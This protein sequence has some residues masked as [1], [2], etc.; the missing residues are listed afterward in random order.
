MELIF[1]KNVKG[2]RGFRFPGS[3][4]PLQAKIDANFARKQDAPL[5]EVAELDVTRH[6]TLLSQKN[7]SIDTHFYPLGSCTMKYNPKFTE[8]LARLAGFT[9]LHPLLPQLAGGEKLTQGA[10]QILHELEALM[11]A[12][13][14]FTQFTLQPLAGA[15]GELTGIMLMAAYHKARGNSKKKYV[16]IPD[17]AHGTNPASA[18]VAGYQTIAIPS[19]KDGG[20]DLAALKA[21]INDEVAGLMMTVPSTYGVFEPNISE[22]AELI[23][24]V[25]GIMYYD[26][27]NLNAV[28]GKCRPGDL[29]FDVMHINTHKTF[30][31]PHGGGGP[32][33]G[34]VGV[35]DKLARY[36][37]VSRVVKNSDGTYALSYDYPDSIGY[38]A[39]FYGNFGLLVRAY[40]YI[41]ML[42]REG[43]I[44][45]ANHAVLNANY[46]MA[47][48]KPYYKLCFDRLC[49]HESVFSASN[50]AAR[51]VH[52]TDI[53]KY[54]IDRQVHP[55]TVYFPISVPE[56]IMIEP[57]ESESLQ[58]MD[59]FIAKMIEA[60]RLSRD[61]PAVFKD[62]PKTMPISRPD[63]TKAARD[64]KTS[65]F[66]S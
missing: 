26:G 7:F 62:L 11:C 5:P 49:M 16:I 50:Q 42:G 37:P 21:A 25:D 4:V 9:D 32:G 43:L 47:R 23:H 10:L 58:T 19:N 34:P 6:Y 51:G 59:D 53:A 41:L 55:P 44:E 1:E 13:T 65:Y 40:A 22:I 2:R 20:M 48:L 52:A 17:S 27:A 60:D 63:E 66:L 61:N 29:G 54:L 28:L 31:T 56:A 33:A 8:A 3:D 39:S 45:T 30:T 57:T 18:A 15:H 24:S 35:N 36:L 64:V 38:I 46:I 12:M 14:G